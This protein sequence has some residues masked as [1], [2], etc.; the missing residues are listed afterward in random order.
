MFLNESAQHNSLAASWPDTNS[1]RPLLL[2]YIH[3]TRGKS[4]FNKMSSINNWFSINYIWNVNK[5]VWVDDRPMNE[6]MLRVTFHFIRILIDL[7]IYQINSTNIYWA[8]TISKALR[9]MVLKRLCIKR[10]F[11]VYFLYSIGL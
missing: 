11:P 5:N 9:G 8:F 4:F 10:I 1:I 7:N 2:K 6:W 3:N